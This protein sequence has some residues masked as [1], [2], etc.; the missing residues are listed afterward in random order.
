MEGTLD[1]GVVYYFSS[2]PQVGAHVGAVGVEGIDVSF[3]AAK[4]SYILTCDF[5][6]FSL[7]GG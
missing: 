2:Y 7:T 6:G 5:Y 1:A 4:D 3:G